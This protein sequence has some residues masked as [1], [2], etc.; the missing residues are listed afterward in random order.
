MTRW[1]DRPDA[2]VGI[3]LHPLRRLRRGFNHIDPVAA[4]VAGELGV[5]LDD[6]AQERQEVGLA[7]ELA[8]DAREDAQVLTL[9]P[10]LAREGAL[11]DLAHGAPR[12]FSSAARQY[13]HS[14]ET[15]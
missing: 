14:T 15:D 5:R 3:P 11:T 12:M 6:R 1:P 10:G 9:A 13:R 8:G 2:L 7:D 4:R